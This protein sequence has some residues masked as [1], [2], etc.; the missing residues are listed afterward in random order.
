VYEI[1]IDLYVAGSFNV[2]ASGL[3]SKEL[4]RTILVTSTGSLSGVNI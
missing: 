2:L 3:F 4:Y 1:Q